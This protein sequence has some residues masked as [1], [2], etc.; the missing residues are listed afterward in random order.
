MKFPCANGYADY[1]C[2]RFTEPSGGPGRAFPALASRDST[3]GWLKI[4]R[5]KLV[6]AAAYLRNFSLLV[7]ATYRALSVLCK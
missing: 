3:L 5:C 4:I 6:L 7:T 1:C 2:A